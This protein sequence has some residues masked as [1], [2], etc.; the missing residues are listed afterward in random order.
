[1]RWGDRVRIYVDEGDPD[2]Q[3]H[4]LVCEVV[5]DHPDDLGNETG[6][7]I[8]SHHYQLR[9]VETGDELRVAFRHGDLVPESEWPVRE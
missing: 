1:M 6:R 8:D 9:R 5:A 3:F 7:D 2:S 4:G